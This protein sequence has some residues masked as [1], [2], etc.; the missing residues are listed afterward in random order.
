VAVLALV[1]LGL[2]AV[3]SQRRPPA[4]TIDP[5]PSETSATASPLQTPTR[6]ATPA[7]SGP[8]P[9][10]D[11]TLYYELIDG[12]RFKEA[13]ALRS[14]RS[15]ARTSLAEF[16]ATWS[17]NN[18]L[19]VESLEV[20][21]RD[22]ATARVR[23]RMLADDFDKARGASSVTPYI[24]KVNLHLEE[25]RWRYD[26]GEFFTDLKSE[27]V[28]DSF[29]RWYRNIPEG[30][31]AARLEELKTRFDPALY[32][33]L[34]KR[35]KLPAEWF[36]GRVTEHSVWVSQKAPETTTVEAAVTNSR[37]TV[38]RLAFRLRFVD[39]E[40]W[41]IEEVSYPE[42]GDTLRDRLGL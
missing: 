19:S 7:P 21:K 23:F 1:V 40:R 12:D 36:G 13:Y 25:D 38:H 37:G 4:P 2:I 31:L 20:L 15:R 27:E 29:Y 16:T 42:R 30:K 33:A 8:D 9:L 3:L 11:L 10:A 24:G 22:A 28:V 17:N 41:V 32:A 39:R 5:S 6:S 18:G 34:R 35:G 14:Q 26:G